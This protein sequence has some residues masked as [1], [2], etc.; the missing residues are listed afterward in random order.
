MKDKRHWLVLGA[1][2]L[3]TASLLSGC[4]GSGSK[5]S[6][7]SLEA[8]PPTLVAQDQAAATRPENLP[9][10][11]EGGL[12]VVTATVKAIDKNNRVVTLQSP[13][14]KIAKV[15]CGPEVRNFAQ[16]RVGDEVKTTLMET[17][18]LFVTGKGEPA[19]ERVTEVG[20]APLGSRPGFAAIDTVE[21]RA[22]VV[23]IDYQTREVTLK[24][25]EGKV[26]KVTAGPEVERLNEVK[27]GDS[28]V[29]RLTRAVSI[30][31]S[32][33]AAN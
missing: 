2:A 5:D 29:A 10:R 12:V 30:E 20:R 27:T 21:V 7:Q 13:D 25:P 15:T 17:V 14:G 3:V 32:K 8:E 33:P 26:I 6:A 23:A 24:G 16:I 18:E 11:L 1:T 28:V 31:V 9:G 19:A 22:S 4:S